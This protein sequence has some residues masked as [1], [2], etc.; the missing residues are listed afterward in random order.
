MAAFRDLQNRSVTVARALMNEFPVLK[1]SESQE[2]KCVAL[3]C[4]SSLEFLLLWLALIRC[5][6]SV[7]LVA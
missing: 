2:E 5:G 6:F 1:A 3:L 4:P 7:L